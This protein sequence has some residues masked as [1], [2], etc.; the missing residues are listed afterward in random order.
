[1]IHLHMMTK[2]WFEIERQVQHSSTM[3]EMFNRLSNDTASYCPL[4]FL[5]PPDYTH[6]LHAAQKKTIFLIIHIPIQLDTFFIILVHNVFSTA[7]TDD[8]LI[9]WEP[10]RG[11]QG[12]VVD[13][14]LRS[15]QVSQ[16]RSTK[17]APNQLRRTGTGV[18][19]FG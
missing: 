3:F 14:R 18:F 13:Q 7:H 17:N 11:A 12:G 5:I 10:T 9:N 19:S 16:L 1:M 2:G 8:K 6:I 4:V 15:V